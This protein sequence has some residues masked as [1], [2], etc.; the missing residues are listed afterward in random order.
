MLVLTPGAY[1]EVLAHADADAPREACGILVGHR[2]DNDAWATRV[3]RTRNVADAPTVEYE[4]DPSEQLSVFE[5][6]AESGRDVLG[7]YHSHPAGPAR[8][9]DRDRGDAAWPGYYYL[10]VSLGGRPPFVDAWTW[11]GERF[12]RVSVVVRRSDGESD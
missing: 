12:E 4:I 3:H 1:E 7:F 6:A 5:S 9:S 10:L 2:E 11:T 8:L